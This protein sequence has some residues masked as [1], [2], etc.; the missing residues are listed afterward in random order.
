MTRKL[1]NCKVV[2]T[3]AVEQNADLAA[4]LAEHGV[5]VVE[6]PL[7][8]IDEPEDDGAERDRTL[9]GFADFEWIVITSPNGAARV[10]PF[11]DAHGAAGDDTEIPNIAAVGA[12]TERALGYPTRLTADP[13]RASVLVEDFPEG[14]G[15]VLVV[16]GERAGDD[17]EV[18]LR[19]KGWNVTRVDAYRTLTLEPTFEQRAEVRS[20][21]AVVFAS[22]SAVQ[23]WF[24]S[25][26][27][28]TPPVVASIGP[29]TTRVANDLGMHVSTTSDAQTVPALAVAVVSAL[30]ADDRPT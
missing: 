20:A 21:D 5:T 23:A 13:A 1:S 4:A 27:A 28:E 25:F 18:G 16:Q 7:I 15:R 14:H 19:A 11:L 12:A 22:G 17:V 9:H 3:R 29:M 8:A 26:G 10:R 24:D 30:L 2:V 6:V